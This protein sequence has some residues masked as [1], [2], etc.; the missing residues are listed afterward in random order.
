MR[1][2]ALMT[3]MLASYTRS[4]RY[5]APLAFTIISVMLIYSYRPNPIMDS[6]AETAALLFIGSAWLGMNFLNHDQG[7][8][9]MLLII[10]AGSP[11]RYYAA[12]Y[13]AAAIIGFMLCIFAVV[14]PVVFDMFG[15][16]M[17]APILA[18]GFAGHFGLS[19]IGISLSLFF[20]PGWIENQGR[21]AG[22]L[23]ILIILS[24]AGKSLV[25]S[26]P[27]FYS[28]IPY[29]LPPVSVMV[30]VLMN[31]RELSTLKISGTVLYLLVYTLVTFAIYLRIACNKDAASLLR[32]SG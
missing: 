23:I 13:G 21:A 3:Y 16:P 5:F 18:L 31:A 14:Y 15:E 12:Q 20:Q 19:L 10:H 9:S 8:Q 4:Y 32:K 28:F 7:R 24:L 22:C 26:L 17:S 2:A 1:S 29:V 27:A 11:R 25:Q 6:Y 30:D